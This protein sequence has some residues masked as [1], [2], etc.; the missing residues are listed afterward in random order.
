MLQ[1][2]HPHVPSASLQGFGFRRDEFASDFLRQ[3]S[4]QDTVQVKN[5]QPWP[6][7]ICC[8]QKTGGNIRRNPPLL[9]RNEMTNL[10]SLLR[11]KRN[12]HGAHPSGGIGLAGGGA[13]FTC[14]GIQNWS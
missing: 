1:R 13:E 2:I 10:A 9:L 3:T 12:L 4:L 11:R 14:P 5:A 6:K 8:R 7:L